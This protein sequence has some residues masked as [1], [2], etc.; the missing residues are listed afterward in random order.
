MVDERITR[1][2]EYS[3]R[4]LKILFDADGEFNI[5]DAVYL[6]CGKVV[7]QGTFVVSIF[8]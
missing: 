6:K 4:S 1:K 2:N 7:L 8:S 3:F 5:L